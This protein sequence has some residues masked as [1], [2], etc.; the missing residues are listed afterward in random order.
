MPYFIFL[1]DYI[2]AIWFKFEKKIVFKKGIK[3][4]HNFNLH[5]ILNIFYKNDLIF[6]IFFK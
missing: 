6:M 3:I 1:A 4:L 2:Q 5:I